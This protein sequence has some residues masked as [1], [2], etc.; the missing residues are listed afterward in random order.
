MLNVLKGL[1]MTRRLTIADARNKGIKYGYRLLSTEYINNSSPL[2]W[3]CPKH[4]PFPMSYQNLGKDG[5]GCHDCFVERHHKEVEEKIYEAAERKGYKVVECVFE[6][7]KDKITLNCPIHSDFDIQIT[8]LLNDH[9]CKKC[10]RMDAKKKIRLSIN[11]VRKRVESLGYE[12]RTDNYINAETKLSMYCPK[13]DFPFE[14]SVH[15]LQKNRICPVCETELKGAKS[16]I[17]KG[18]KRKHVYGIQIKQLAK[19][20]NIKLISEIEDAVLYDK[21][22]YKIAFI[23]EKHGLRE[24]TF[25]RL[26]GN[27][28]PCVLCA[29]EATGNSKYISYEEIEETARKHGYILKTTRDEYENVSTELKLVCPKHGE[30]PLLARKLREGVHCKECGREI[31]REKVSGENCIFWKGGSTN[32]VQHFRAL[33]VPWRNKRIVEE[34]RKCELTGRT[35]HNL[36]VHHINFSFSDI[37]WKT[38]NDIGIDVREKVADYTE[39]EIIALDNKFMENHNN[40]AVGVVMSEDIHNDF[41]DYCGG[42][43]TTTTIEQLKMFCDN[44]HYHFPD[45]YISMIN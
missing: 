7:Q 25:K 43:N 18:N 24:A 22:Q 1:L 26:K 37:A 29:N 4:G 17:R 21:E 33:T 36:E 10:G 27:K 2:L 23:C 40:M 32:I 45:K 39:E 6:T 20:L 15:D 41:H 13:H 38:I 28:Y 5:R 19:K 31:Q 42:C 30:F 3:D 12:L 16:K 9:G 44:N 11:E 8:S 34:N 35:S 14:Q